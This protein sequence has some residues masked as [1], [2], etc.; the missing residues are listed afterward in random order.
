[1]TEESQK[2]NDFLSELSDREESYRR[3]YCHGFLAAKRT[4]VTQEEIYEWR[5]SNQLTA[6]PGSCLEGMK[7]NGLTKADEHRFFI[8]RLKPMEEN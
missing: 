2:L 7:L 5:H 1:M 6:P 3:G 4:D 8:N